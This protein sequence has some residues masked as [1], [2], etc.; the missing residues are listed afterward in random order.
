MKAKPGL[1]FQTLSVPNA[2]D[3]LSCDRQSCGLRPRMCASSHRQLNGLAARAGGSGSEGGPLAERITALEQ[4]SA[5][6]SLAEQLSALEQAVES[7]RRSVTSSHTRDSAMVR[8]LRLL[9]VRPA[10]YLPQHCRCLSLDGCCVWASSDRTALD[11]RQHCRRNSSFAACVGR[12]RFV[13]TILALRSVD[14]SLSCI[15][16][17]RS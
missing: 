6:G 12:C 1:C 2:V 13:H 9:Q 4:A 11:S 7:L 14:S 16:V 3:A 8:A 17:C 15:A 10:L 5:G